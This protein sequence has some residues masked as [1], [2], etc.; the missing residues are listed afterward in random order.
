MAQGLAVATT[1]GARARLSELLE[2]DEE[3]EAARNSKA[4]FLTVSRG[5]GAASQGHVCGPAVL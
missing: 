4:N 2:V 3:E 1:D 5:G